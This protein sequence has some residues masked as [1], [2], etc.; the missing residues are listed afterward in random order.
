MLFV[1]G[2]FRRRRDF[3][4]KISRLCS[5]TADARRAPGVRGS[6]RAMP[7][8][9]ASVE[10]AVGVDDDDP[11]ELLAVYECIYA[12]KPLPAKP[13]EEENVDAEARKIVSSVFGDEDKENVGEDGAVSRG[14]LGETEKTNAERVSTVALSAPEDETTAFLPPH[15]GRLKMHE[16]ALHFEADM[17]GLDLTSLKLMRW[18]I[19]RADAAPARYTVTVVDWHGVPHDFQLHKQA[20]ELHERMVRA[21]RLERADADASADDFGSLVSATNPLCQDPLDP[22]SKIGREALEA[23]ERLMARLESRKNSL[24]GK[25]ASFAYPYVREGLRLARAAAKTYGV[26]KDFLFPPPPPPPPGVTHRGRARE[27]EPV[28]VRARREGGVAA[29]NGQRRRLRPLRD[30]A[31][32]LARVHDGDC[33]RDRG[34]GVGRDVR[35]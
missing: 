4:E 26:A 24:R 21:W 10:K 30:G 32:G 2:S 9:A 13:S 18:Q 22:A 1:A 28:F 8:L 29:G 5:T 23:R 15:V 31:L 20:A 17:F 34:P 33:V 6:A 27:D 35:V 12:G 25:A 14:K 16:D 3:S 11:G 7:S 19:K